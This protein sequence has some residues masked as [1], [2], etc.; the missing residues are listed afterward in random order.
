MKMNEDEKKKSW[1]EKRKA[2]KEEKKKTKEAT[3]LFRKQRRNFRLFMWTTIIICFGIPI[4]GHFWFHLNWLTLVILIFICG[5]L[6]NWAYNRRARKI[7]EEANK[8]QKQRSEYKNKTSLS[9]QREK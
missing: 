7:E 8:E 6:L 3:K 4:V 9:Y 2:R 5:G 1:K